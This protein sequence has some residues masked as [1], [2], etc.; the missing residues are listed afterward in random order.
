MKR[1]RDLLA[2]GKADEAKQQFVAA[3]KFLDKAAKKRAFHPNAV[4]RYKSNLAAALKAGPKAAPAKA[5]AK[6]A[7]KKTAPKKATPNKP[8]PKAADTPTKKK[9]AKE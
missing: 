4:A 2:E 9:S 6:P 1:V 5:K 7:V 8:A 3:Q